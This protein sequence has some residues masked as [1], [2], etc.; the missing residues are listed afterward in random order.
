VSEGKHKEY[1]KGEEKLTKGMMVAHLCHLG[2]V[3]AISTLEGGLKISKDLQEHIGCSEVC[4]VEQ[5]DDSSLLDFLKEC[6]EVIL[7]ET[8]QIS[9]ETL[10][11]DSSVIT[12]E[13]NKDK[14]TVSE[15]KHEIQK[16]L[17]TR[18]SLQELYMVNSLHREISIIGDEKQNQS[19]DSLLDND[20]VLLDNDA[21]TID[22]SCT[23]LLCVK[24]SLFNNSEEVGFLIYLCYILGLLHA[25]PLLLITGP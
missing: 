7:V 16:A 14:N 21:E 3:E 20:S 5:L 22:E 12:L 15:L 11:G 1:Y 9:V 10:S 17:G 2:K 13:R 19:L 8:M 6:H 24:D 25:H 18:E 23:V 4:Q